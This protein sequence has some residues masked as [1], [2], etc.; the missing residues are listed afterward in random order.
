MKKMYNY[1]FALSLI[2]CSIVTANAQ[3]IFKE[4]FDYPAG[5]LEGKNGGT[6]FT[7]GWSKTGTNAAASIGADDK[8]TV[9]AGSIATTGGVGNRVQLCLEE[10]KTVRLDRTLPVSMN[11]VKG[12]NY[13]FGFWY[14]S[15]SD[16]AANTVNIG[17]QLMF[18]S[19]P[20]TTD[21]LTQRL[22]LGKHAVGGTVNTLNVASRSESCTATAAGGAARTWG[23]GL[24]P[25][26]T[27]YILSK[28]TKGDSVAA[29]GTNFDI[30]RTWVLSARPANEAALAASPN[31][32][33]TTGKV[34]IRSLRADN[35]SFCTADGIKGIRIRIE[36]GS[37]TGNGAY[38]VEFDDMRLGTNL[39]SVLAGVNPVKDAAADYF[40]YDI[41]PNPASDF[42]TLNLTMKKS[43]KADIGVFDVAGKRVATVG[44][45]FY[46]EGVHTL[47]VKTA[48]MPA[49]IYF[50]KMQMENGVQQSTKLIVA[51]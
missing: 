19:V 41:S 27:Y 43:G 33:T 51:K 39:A 31:G 29:D 10:G 28:I 18:L 35:N 36:S 4:D 46:T 11:G 47:D 13:W 9:L 17:A 37:A 21:N 6:G 23:T 22:M 42:S 12:T 16:T 49:G 24:S 44:S 32:N 15:T 40:K 45:G 48:T 20:S 2:V 34:A 38:C 3:L 8:A 26:G 25:K 1:L 30:V 5:V 14:R 50:V 7:T